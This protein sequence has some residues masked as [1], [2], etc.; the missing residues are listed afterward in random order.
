MPTTKPVAPTLAKTRPL[1][2]A[3]SIGHL[4]RAEQIALATALLNPPEPGPRLQ[5]AAAKYRARNLSRR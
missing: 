4:P 5:Q 2:Q 1:R 3:A